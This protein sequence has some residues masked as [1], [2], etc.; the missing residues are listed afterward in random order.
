MTKHLVIRGT[1]DAGLCG[2]CGLG[3]DLTMMECNPELMKEIEDKIR[4]MEKKK[5]G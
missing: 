4:E 2:R 1:I 5:H 3:G